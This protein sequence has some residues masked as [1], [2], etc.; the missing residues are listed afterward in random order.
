M[1]RVWSV[2]SEVL[3]DSPCPQGV[4]AKDSAG[5]VALISVAEAAKR[6]PDALTVEVLESLPHAAVSYI[7]RDAACAAGIVVIP[8][9]R[10]P[11]R[12]ARRFAF[13]VL[14]GELVLVEDGSTCAELLDQLQAEKVPVGSAHG[15]FVALVRLLLRDH[16]AKLS[17]VRED[18]ELIEELILEGRERVNRSLMREDARRLLGID[19]FYQ[20]LTDILGELADEGEGLI[21][22]AVRPRLAALARQV[23]RLSTRLEALQDYCLQ[24]Q[25]LYQESIDIRQNNVMQWLTVVTTIAM[26]LTFIT[27][28]YGMNFPHMALFDVPWGYIAVVA[29]CA[30]IVV[31]EIAFFHRQG[32][33][34]F[35]G[36]VS[37]DARGARGRAKR[38]AGADARRRGEGA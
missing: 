1:E 16:P 11:Q 2:R 18:F 4:E 13:I 25:A 36:R 20:G 17:R 29:V 23:E 15:A 33:L 3:A 28:W 19:G 14:P 9:A 30:A 21:D 26:P 31:L 12:E 37:R 34:S 35:G 32:W 24:V 27:G 6:F 7:E 22:P 10:R 5:R 38:A 8:T